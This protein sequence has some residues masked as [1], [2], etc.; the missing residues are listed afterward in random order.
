MTETSTDKIRILLVDDHSLF[1]EGIMQLL[2]AEGDLDVV[3]QCSTV[4]EAAELL[5]NT[6]VDLILLDYD[7]YGRPG[8]E[9]F[10]YLHE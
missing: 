6:E 7:L 2:T 8:S 10:Y 9:L 5:R 1:R 4:S 3:A